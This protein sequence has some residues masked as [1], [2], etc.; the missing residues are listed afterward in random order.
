[1]IPRPFRNAMLSAGLVYALTIVHHIY[2]AIAFET[3]WRYH[4]AFLGLGATVATFVVTRGAAHGRGHR[5]RQAAFALLLGLT[6]VLAVALVGLF[7]GG[8]NHGLK[9]ALFFVGAAPATM[10]RL[11]PPPT[12]EMPGDVFFE[13]T[14]VL[15]L[16][17][18]LVAA[19]ACITLWRARR[20]WLPV[21]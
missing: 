4:A 13:A 11:F 8:Y 7:E 15:Q 20:R 21:G 19:R 2:G 10:R 12:Y 3:P 16:F 6:L 1:V 9:V 17:A 5:L 18:G 14:G